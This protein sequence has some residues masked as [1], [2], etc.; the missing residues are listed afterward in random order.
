MYTHGTA[1]VCWPKLCGYCDPVDSKEAQDLRENTNIFVVV[2]VG[3]KEAQ[4]L[5]ENTNIFVVVFMGDKERASTV[6]EDS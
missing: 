5:H 6:K 3:D 1:S 4:D 2:F